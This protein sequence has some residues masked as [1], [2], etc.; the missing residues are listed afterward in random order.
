MGSLKNM[1]KQRK[2]ENIHLI[3]YKMNRYIYTIT[4]TTQYRTIER[5]RKALD[6]IIRLNFGSANIQN[7]QIK[8]TDII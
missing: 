6:E 8:I 4:I 5:A 3:S 1:L 7:T 2:L